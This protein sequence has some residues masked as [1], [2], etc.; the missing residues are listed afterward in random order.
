MS[1]SLLQV[2]FKL[3]TV[4]HYTFAHVFIRNYVTEQGVPLVHTDGIFLH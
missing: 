2:Q 3:N 1:G 4:G